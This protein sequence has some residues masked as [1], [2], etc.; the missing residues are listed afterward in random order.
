MAPGTERAPGCAPKF[1]DRAIETVLTLRM[2][3]HPPLRRAE[4]FLRSVL[5]VMGLDLE[6]PDPMTLSRRGP[7]LALDLRAVPH[8]GTV[9]L[10][11][12]SHV[13]SQV[14]NAS[15]ST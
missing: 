6:S 7:G 9:H 15:Q 2:V 13:F 5:R 1:S 10:L 8:Q 14:Q 11:I 3:F 12:D 4:G